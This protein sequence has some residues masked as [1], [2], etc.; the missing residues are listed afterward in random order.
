MEGPHRQCAT[1][2]AERYGSWQMLYTRFRRWALDGAFS[3]MSVAGQADA[4]AVGDVDWPVTV[5]STIPRF[6]VRAHACT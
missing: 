6:Q 3:A 5:D 4:D 1:G 2:R